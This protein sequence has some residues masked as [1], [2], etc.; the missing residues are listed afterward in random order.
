MNGLSYQLIQVQKF[1]DPEL[2]YVVCFNLNAEERPDSWNV[3]RQ[4]R[5]HTPIVGH[6]DL[7]SSIALNPTN[8][9]AFAM[10]EK[11]AVTPSGPN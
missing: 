6:N 7:Q 3:L 8:T 10:L 5:R 2:C 11:A 1:D 4:S 9:R